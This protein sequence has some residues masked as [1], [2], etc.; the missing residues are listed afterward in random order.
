MLTDWRELRHN[1][2]HKLS[3]TPNE[4]PINCTFGQES[5]PVEIKKLKVT[6]PTSKID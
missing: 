1:I 6:K 2:R 3:E 5:K 4:D